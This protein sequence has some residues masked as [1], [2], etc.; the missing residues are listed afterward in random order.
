VIDLAQPAHANRAAKEN[1]E[2]KYFI[3]AE[4]QASSFSFRGLSEPDARPLA[5]LL[6]ED[7]ADSRAARIVSIV[8]RCA[9]SKSG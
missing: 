5:V 4:P 6:D 2:N 8:R 3:C 7:L 1:K 9:A